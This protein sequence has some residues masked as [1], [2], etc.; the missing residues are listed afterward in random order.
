MLAAKVVDE[1]LERVSGTIGCSVS[2]L[3]R[4]LSGQ[5]GPGL[6]IAYAAQQFYG[7]PLEAWSQRG[8]SKSEQRRLG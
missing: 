1:G 8:L 5:R 7:I 3:Y 4:L 6:H 2:H